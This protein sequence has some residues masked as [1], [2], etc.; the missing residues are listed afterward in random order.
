MLYLIRGVPGSGKTTYALGLQKDLPDRP[1]V[2]EADQWMTLDG[3]YVWRTH[4]LGACHDMCRA[5]AKYD[6]AQGKSV[7]VSNTSTT[8]WEVSGYVQLAAQYGHEVTIIEMTGDHGNVH[9]V[10]PDKIKEMKAR[11]VS[12]EDLQKEFSVGFP[13]VTIHYFT[14]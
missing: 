8:S 5:H 2:Y 11:F 6:L 12:N 13:D 14:L 1:E 7:I 9:G 3:V 4:L 10:P